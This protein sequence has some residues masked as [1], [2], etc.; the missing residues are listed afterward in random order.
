MLFR[1]EYRALL[2]AANRDGRL[3]ARAVELGYM[4]PNSTPRDLERIIVDAICKAG[5]EILDR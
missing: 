4:D 5:G 2:Q 1:D 3:H